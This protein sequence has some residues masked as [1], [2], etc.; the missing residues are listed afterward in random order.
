MQTSQGRLHLTSG[1]IRP[2]AAASRK[3]HRLLPDVPTLEKL[4]NDRMGGS[5]GHADGLAAAPQWRAR[6]IL[7]MA[8][9]RKRLIDQAADIAGGHAHRFRCVYERGT[10]PLRG[11]RQKGRHQAGMSRGH[12]ARRHIRR[13]HT[14]SCSRKRASLFVTAGALVRRNANRAGRVAA[15]RRAMI[16]SSMTRKIDG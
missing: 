15:T 11:C 10:Q 7:E 14:A 3:R 8:N 6:Q 12:Y 4:S 2:L 1:Q 13:C 5:G 16:R 9:I